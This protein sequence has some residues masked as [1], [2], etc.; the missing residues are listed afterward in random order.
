MFDALNHWATA[1]MNNIKHYSPQGR[2]PFSAS[3]IRYSLLLCYTSAQSYKL[4]LDQ[5]P[6]PSFKS[7]RK[8]QSGGLDAIKAVQLMLNKELVT[9]DCVLLV[10]EMYLK[11]GAQYHG[12]SY[13]GEDEEGNLY[14]GIVVFMIIGIQKSVPY[15]VKSSPE[16]H[17]TGSW[18]KT[19]ID[20]CILELQKVGFKV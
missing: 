12:G 13:V 19:E 5:L 17:I 4:L 15:V 18:L 3:L 16:V 20:L 8:I 2:P 14:K 10:N 11:K 1:E 6:L 9:S 7:L